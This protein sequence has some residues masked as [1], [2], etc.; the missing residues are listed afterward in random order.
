MHGAAGA[1][2]RGG[3]V[4]LAWG[5]YRVAAPCAG[6]LLPAARVLVPAAERARWDERLGRT[7]LAGGA[8]AWIHAASM[9]EAVAAGALMRGLAAA[10]PAGA[11][12]RAARFLLSATTRAGRERLAGFGVPAVMAPLDTPQSAGRFFTGVA[13]R[14]VFVVETELWPQWLLRA[15]EGRVPVA[16]VSARLSDRSVRGYRRLGTPLR[17]L[18]AGLAGVLCQTAEDAE[19]W[20]RLGAAAGVC[21]VT[22]NLKDDGLRVG[23]RDRAA[24]RR[25]LGLDPERPLLVLGSVRPGEARALAEA[26]LRLPVALRERWQVA[27]LPRHPQASDGLRA[28]AE[29]AGQP[30][31][32][33]GAAAPGAWCWDERLGVLNDY[34]A[35]AEIAFV[36]GSLGPYGGHNPLEPAACGAALLMGPDHGA[37]ADAVRALEGAGGLR[38]VAAGEELSRALAEWLGDE[39]ARTG[40]GEAALAVAADRQGAVQ[41]TVDWLEEHGLW[42]VA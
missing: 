39:G 1:G 16:I 10:R 24:G 31:A 42:P 35:A 17:E 7:T 9:G 29:A 3:L 4:S 34:Y 23:T 6:A 14:R 21:I 27:A 15:R 11:G 12:A 37:Q 36:G 28:E 13:P 5:L 32:S 8:D 18:V 38:V 33:P 41:R 25:A 19:R 30:V 2:R 26:W 22:G 40:A 20:R